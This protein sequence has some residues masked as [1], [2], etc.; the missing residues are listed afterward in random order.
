M[1][2][3]SNTNKRNVQHNVANTQLKNKPSSKW[4]LINKEANFFDKAFEENLINFQKMS[5]KEDEY[6][7]QKEG[8]IEE[9]II[10]T[11]KKLKRK[12]KKKKYK[13]I[14]FYGMS[15]NVLSIFFQ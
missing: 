5:L 14:L 3:N 6:S 9:K 11:R 10:R 2:K 8:S 12:K 4:R 13:V 1:G 15:H 7:L